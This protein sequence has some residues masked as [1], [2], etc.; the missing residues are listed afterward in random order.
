MKLGK[1]SLYAQSIRMDLDDEYIIRFESWLIETNNEKVVVHEAL[2]NGEHVSKCMSDPGS[3][4][5]EDVE[6]RVLC[7]LG[8]ICSNT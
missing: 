7:H 6:K 3:D 5:I 1:N 8:K 4:K 2:P